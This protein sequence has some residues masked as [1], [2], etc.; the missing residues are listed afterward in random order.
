V[1]LQSVSEY[2]NDCHDTQN[3]FVHASVSLHHSTDTAV[4]PGF[5]KGEEQVLSMRL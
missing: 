5:A 3:H 4:D 2:I 1:D